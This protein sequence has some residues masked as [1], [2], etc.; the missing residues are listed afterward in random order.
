MA[1]GLYFGGE[2]EAS[3]EFVLAQQGK[4]WYANHRE[5]AVA[6]NGSLD[7]LLDV[8]S[9][10]VGKIGV[11]AA[12]AFLYDWFSVTSHTVSLGGSLEA[13][14]ANQFFQASTSGDFS[15]D[16][17]HTASYEVNDLRASGVIGGGSKQ[18]P[19]PGQKES[20]LILG[21]G[22]YALKLQNVSG[23][24]LDVAVTFSWAEPS[25]PNIPS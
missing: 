7:I 9:S 17:L 6:D 5:L 21:P 23:G 19:I 13:W 20:N 1:Q 25:I 11:E 24:A 18:N 15:V 10:W 14:N 4:M 12:G 2:I 8:K 22:Q 3:A 16:Y